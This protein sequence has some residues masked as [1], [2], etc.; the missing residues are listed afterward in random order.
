MHCVRFS[1]LLTCLCV[2]VATYSVRFIAISYFFHYSCIVLY[3]RVMGIVIGGRRRTAAIAAAEA[4]NAWG[5]KRGAGGAISLIRCGAVR[6]IV[7]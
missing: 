4:H 2:C 7:L 3:C 6:P 5:A 1:L